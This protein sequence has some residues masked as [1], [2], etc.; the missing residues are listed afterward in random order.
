MPKTN[1]N[2]TQKKLSSINGNRYERNHKQ[3]IPA[4]FE[5]TRYTGGCKKNGCVDC[6][7]ETKT[8][9]DLRNDS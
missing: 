4:Y 1:H 6:K 8:I 9:G 3:P 2:R 5:N 7:G